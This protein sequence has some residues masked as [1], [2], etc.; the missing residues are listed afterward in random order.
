MEKAHV[1]RVFSCPNETVTVIR[2][3]KV[4]YKQMSFIRQ[5][6]KYP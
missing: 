2:S 3:S 6:S 4:C 1:T 5:Q